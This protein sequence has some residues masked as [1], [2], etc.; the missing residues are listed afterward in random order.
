MLFERLNRLKKFETWPFECFEDYE[1]IS[2]KL[3]I[4]NESLVV[5]YEKIEQLSNFYKVIKEKLMYYSKNWSSLQYT[6]PI[7]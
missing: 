1:A 2:K 4:K 5:E 6:H 3:V 7:P